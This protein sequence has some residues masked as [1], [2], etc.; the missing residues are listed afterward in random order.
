MIE[1]SMCSCIPNN[2][3]L[4]KCKTLKITAADEL[5]ENCA[6]LFNSSYYGNK[7][8]LM[9]MVG[10]LGPWSDLFSARAWPEVDWVQLF[11]CKA[12]CNQLISF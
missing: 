12:I 1:R 7:F 4:V 3:C 5:M 2:V 10:F 11:L 9:H 8:R 6:H